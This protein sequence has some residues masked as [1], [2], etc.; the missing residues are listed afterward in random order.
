MQRR[1]FL[2]TV[3]TVAPGAL[4]AP[5]A[6]AASPGKHNIKNLSKQKEPRVFFFDDGRHAADLYCFEPPVT[7]EDHTFIVDQLANSGVDALV[8]FA[9]VEGGSALYDSKAVQVWGDEVK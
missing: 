8:Y 9:S 6:H 1:K 3:G 4:A 7:P 5:L 2:R